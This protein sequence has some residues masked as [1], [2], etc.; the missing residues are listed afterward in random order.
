MLYTYGGAL[1]MA[2]ALLKARGKAKVSVWA[3]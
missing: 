2:R 3:P 1:G